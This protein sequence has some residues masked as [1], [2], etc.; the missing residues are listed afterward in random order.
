M[1]VK[2]KADHEEEKVKLIIIYR[3]FNTN[4]LFDNVFKII[5]KPFFN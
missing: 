2:L 1:A 4:P 5:I 3:I